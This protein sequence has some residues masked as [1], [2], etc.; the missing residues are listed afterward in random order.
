MGKREVIPAAKTFERRFACHE[1]HPGLC[2]H[3]DAAVYASTI[4]FVQNLERLIVA[5]DRDSGPLH[6]ASN[7]GPE[8]QM[9]A[10]L[11]GRRARRP[12]APQVLVFA[13][14]RE[15]TRDDDRSVIAFEEQ[16]PWPHVINTG[17]AFLSAW[18]LGRAWTRA[19][20]S[21]RPRTL[22]LDRFLF[23]VLREGSFVLG[24]SILHEQDIAMSF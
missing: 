12:Y 23:E 17:Y 3:A 9:I 15:I 14:V 20:R 11:A 13:G 7:G 18:S 19:S 5:V 1:R 2:W 24:S 16:L 8:F 21:Q 6:F 22:S 10:Y 4:A